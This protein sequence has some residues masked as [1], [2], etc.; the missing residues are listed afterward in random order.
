[1][2]VR[3]TLRLR[4]DAL[5][6]AREKRG[7]TQKATAEGSGV[8][9]HILSG[10]E[11]LQ[12]DADKYFADAV[13]YLQGEGISDRSYYEQDLVVS[14]ARGVKT[15]VNCARK[16]AAFLELELEEVLPS[17]GG[18]QIRDVTKVAEVQPEQLAALC[19]G[20]GS[21][22]K[23]LACN[24]TESAER[25]EG[26]D[27]LNQAIDALGERTAFVLRKRYGLGCEAA[28]LR[29]IGE[30]IGLCQESVRQIEC[31]GVRD[32]Q[33]PGVAHL[34]REATRD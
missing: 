13:R 34:L 19:A 21:H 24:P 23:R 4:N 17:L 32:L 26:H 28:S 12:Y 5:L 6:S 3:A 9:I 15:V 16:I 7:L 31:K 11:R 25:S 29:E 14:G 30:E 27:L 18:V 33:K 8:P 2:K 20:V 10:L 1:M 22:T